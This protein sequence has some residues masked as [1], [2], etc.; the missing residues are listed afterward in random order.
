MERFL[1][2]FIDLVE[3]WAVLLLVL[4]VVLVLLGVFFRY[5]VNQAL[6]W[7]D[8]FASY[9]LVWLTFYAAVVA[10][11]RRRHIGFEVVVDRLAPPT[12]RV[13]EFV[14]ES[15]VLGFQF[16]LFYYGWVLTGKM[17]DESA[18]SLDW[19]KM[20]WVYSVLP[21]AGGLMLVISL[22]RLARIGF[23]KGD[24]RR[25]GEAWSGSSSGSSSS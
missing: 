18:V 21:I 12:R 13:L 24:R 19:V 1:R 22:V 5:V 20:G 16:V 7:Y 3:W 11:Y 15:C 4:M 8:E 14:G 17:G 6:V 10:S 25:G 9:L 23:R 2:R